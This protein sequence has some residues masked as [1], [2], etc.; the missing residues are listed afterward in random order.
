MLSDNDFIKK[1]GKDIAIYPFK[2][3]NIEGASVFLTASEH[4][5]SLNS[6]QKNII[7]DGKIRI[8]KNDI[9]MIVTNESVYLSKNIAGTCYL[10]VS[11]AFRGFGQIGGPIKLG[12]TGKLLIAIHNIYQKED[13]LD[14]DIGEKIAVLMF[15]KLTS[16][17]KKLESKIPT[18]FLGEHGFTLTQMDRD[19]F[20]DVVNTDGKEIIAKMNDENEYKQYKKTTKPKYTFYIIFTIIVFLLVV[21]LIALFVRPE[22]NI[23]QITAQITSALVIFMLGMKIK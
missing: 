12:S 14:I 23:L 21:Q 11:F 19:K 10:R 6:K 15:H 8:P 3:E 22:W 16:G 13:Y 4:V 18:S 20:D 17:A 9:A 2:K 5:W 1:F 7:V